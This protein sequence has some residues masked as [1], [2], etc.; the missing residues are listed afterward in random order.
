MRERGGNRAGII[1]RVPA[2]AQQ[3]ERHAGGAKR[4]L[5][6]PVLLRKRQ[7]RGVRVQDARIGDEAHAGPL[8]G[9]DDVAVLL[10][11]LADLARRD[12]KQLV[13]AVEGVR[14]GF[15]TRIIGDAN[16]DPEV[17]Q[18]PGRFA[19]RVAHARGDLPGRHPLQQGLDDEA[20][21]LAGR[22]GHHEA[23]V[24]GCGHDAAPLVFHRDM[25]CNRDRRT[26]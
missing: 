8:G 10:H 17:A 21:E 23:G 1:L 19:V 14:E 9:V 5:G 22:A 4:R 15:G 12:E 6:L 26:V 20:A 13:D 18:A 3:H 7:R 16:L 25:V 11:T 24:R 2:V